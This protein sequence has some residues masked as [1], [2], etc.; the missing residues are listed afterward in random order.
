MLP[1]A[2]AFVPSV[3]SVSAESLEQALSSIFVSTSPFVPATS[4]V[5]AVAETKAFV[6][7]TRT[8]GRWS[9]PVA[10]KSV[11]QRKALGFTVVTPVRSHSSTDV[12]VNFE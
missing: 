4:P 2:S 10:L 9:V 1:N 3:R 8:L 7:M 5:M 11:E 6:P 12:F